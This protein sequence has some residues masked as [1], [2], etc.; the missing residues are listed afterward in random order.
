VQDLLIFIG[1]V[2]LMIGF[3]CSGLFAQRST[4]LLSQEEKLTLVDSPSRLR[5]FGAV[6]LV[7]MSVHILRVIA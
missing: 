1:L 3:V 7:L 2:L 5:V 4:K 6:P